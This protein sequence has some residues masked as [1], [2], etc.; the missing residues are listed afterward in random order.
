MMVSKWVAAMATAAVAVSVAVPAMAGPFKKPEISK[1]DLKKPDTSSMECN[2]DKGVEQLGKDMDDKAYD[3][4]VSSN[5]ALASMQDAAGKKDEAKKTRDSG[6]SWTKENAPSGVARIKEI[7]RINDSLQTGADWMQK[8]EKYDDTAKNA[9]KES[10]SALR[11]AVLKVAWGAKI[12]E[13][14]PGKSK[15]AIEG[16]AACTK[17]VKGAADAAAGIATLLGSMKKTYSAVDAAAKKAGN[18]DLTAEEKAKQDSESGV[19]SG[20]GV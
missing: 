1:P 3:A 9:L 17:K 2:D 13:P 14:V 11:K 6:K 20:L 19:P 4:L 16:S 18:G 5:E 12:G 10:R 15:E 7:N 8:Q